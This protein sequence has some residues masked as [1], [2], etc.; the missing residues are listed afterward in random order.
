MKRI[1]S[2]ILTSIL[3][4]SMLSPTFGAPSDKELYNEAGEI[5]KNAGILK[6][7]ET[8]NLM[9]E[10]NL[11]R[12]DMV[13]LISRLYKQENTAKKYPIKNTFSDVKNSF[14][15]PYIS[16]AVDKGL[17]VGMGN[18]E[19]GFS[20]PVTVQQFQTLLLKTLKYSEEAKN[21]NN[22]P[23]IAKHFKLMEGL[24]ATPKQNLDR[25]LMAA[26]TVNALRVEMKGE[27]FTLAK[28]LNLNI[29]EPLKVDEIAKVD[30]NTLKLEGIAKG[31]NGLKVN[32]KPIS[33]NI[34]SG[35]KQ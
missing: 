8:G 10:K 26:M 9:L 2:L 33:N 30:K 27:S 23:E 16:W 15:K 22:V 14:Y 20:D 25:G 6:G 4:L 1:L 34:T 3:V 24:S 11:K 29:P 31:I 28:H 17:I 32:L 35:Q 7:S 5:L 18:N 21:W 19:F 12:Q 13:I